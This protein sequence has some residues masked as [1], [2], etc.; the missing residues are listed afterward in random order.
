MIEQEYQDLK[1]IYIKHIKTYLKETGGLFPHVTI[2]ADHLDKTEHPT[3]AIIHIPIPDQ[4]MN[5]DDSKDEFVDVVLPEVMKT[6]K[7]KFEVHAI[8]WAS[9][10][11]M[12][13]ADKDFDFDNQDYK[14]LPKTEVLFVSIESQDREETQIYEIKRIGMKVTDE[15]DLC[16]DVELTEITEFGNPEHTEGRFSGLY[17]KLIKNEEIN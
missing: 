4:Y 13:R 7:E 1:D 16:D 3:N 2:L 6:V 12:R 8:A 14:Q 9:E 11:W 17:K 15:G 5:D 10:A